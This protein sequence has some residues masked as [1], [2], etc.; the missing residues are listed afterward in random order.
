MNIGIGRQ[1]GANNPGGSHSG[2]RD[3]D[4]GG[5]Q[6]RKADDGAAEHPTTAI[7]EYEGTAVEKSGL[8]ER[9]TRTRHNLRYSNTGC[10]IE[11]QCR[12]LQLIHLGPS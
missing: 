3:Q 8:R 2:K 1:T 12:A 5:C 9:D 7:A 4:A 6:G 10:R 11:A